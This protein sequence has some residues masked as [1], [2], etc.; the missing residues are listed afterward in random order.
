MDARL[1]LMFLVLV[2]LVSP[3]LGGAQ[4]EAAGAKLAG[5]PR[6]DAVV[7]GF[8]TPQQHVD[9]ASSQQRSRQNVG[10]PVALMIVGGAAVVLGAFIGGDVGTLFMIG[11]AVAILF[12]LYRYFQ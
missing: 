11:G 9:Y 8:R 3:S 6:L 10:K 7:T 12:G 5:G 4:Q 1:R 2:A